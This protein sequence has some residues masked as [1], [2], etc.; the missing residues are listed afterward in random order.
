MKEMF[1]KEM[2]VKE[3]SVFN[4]LSITPLLKLKNRIVLAPLYYEWEFGSRAFMKFFET[5]AKGGI[6]MAVV[7]ICIGPHELNNLSGADRENFIAKSRSFIELMHS[8]DCKVL[9]QVFSGVGEDVNQLSLEQ[10]NTLPDAF[11]GASRLLYEAGYDG[12]DIH[13]AH[14]SLFMSLIS[15]AINQ[16]QDRFGGSEA[17]RFQ[18]PLNT[19]KAI[20]AAIKDFPIFYRFSAVDFINQGF[21]IEQ[22]VRFAKALCDAG[23]SCIDV[24]A[25]GTHLSPLYSDAPGEEA[26]EACFAIYSSAI[27]Q[28]VPIPVMVAGRINLLSTAEEIVDNFHAD[29]LAIGRALVRN[30]DWIEEIQENQ[31]ACL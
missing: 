24:S 26:G 22:G 2:S 1:V 8:Y 6:A 27:K 10:L 16:R 21:D 29:L 30:P 4:S 13:G 5:R 18:L 3:S 12:I 17:N 19:I 14:H 9:P 11:A 28:A 31:A 23:V 20:H 7:P 15:P 25:G